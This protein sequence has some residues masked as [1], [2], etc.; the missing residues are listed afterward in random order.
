MNLEEKLNG[1]Y[2]EMDREMLIPFVTALYKSVGTNTEG[3]R[4]N[5]TSSGGINIEWRK[6]SQDV[7]VISMRFYSLD[8]ST[9][10]MG[11]D[12]VSY[13][14]LHELDDEDKLRLEMAV[15]TIVHF[16]RGVWKSI[17]MIPA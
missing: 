1:K 4:I 8:K 2:F 7:S 5:N 17:K 11:F 15:N 16:A 13:K 12:P 9:A 3:I 10:F 6:A 14:N